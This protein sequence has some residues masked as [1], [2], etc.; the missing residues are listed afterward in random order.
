MF[1]TSTVSLSETSRLW[2][3]RGSIV[4]HARFSDWSEL[5]RTA[6]SRASNLRSTP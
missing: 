4:T 6:Q 5:V 3:T 1:E 2:W